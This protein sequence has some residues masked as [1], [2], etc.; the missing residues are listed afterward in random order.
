MKVVW[1]EEALAHLDGIYRYIAVDAP[2]YAQRVVDKITR[3]SEH[4]GAHPHAGRVVPEHHDATLPEL[5]VFPYR[6]IYRLRID[7]LDIIAVFHGA[8]LLSEI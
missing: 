7:R 6:L 8:R 2:L 1:T 3:H 4:L 5:I